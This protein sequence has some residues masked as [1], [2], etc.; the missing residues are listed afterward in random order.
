MLVPR[1]EALPAPLAPRSTK[2]PRTSS[3]AFRASRRGE[4]EA[5]DDPAAFWETYRE[6]AGLV[7]LGAGAAEGKL[8][9][10]AGKG[11][12]AD[13]E[14]D[15]PSDDAWGVERD[16][17]DVGDVRALSWAGLLHPWAL[18]RALETVWASE[19]CVFPSSTPRSPSRAALLP[20][21]T[22]PE[23]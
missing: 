10:A 11:G 6:W 15:K 13:D 19:R 7:A 2:K 23:S 16:K 3:G 22:S 1:P 21:L 9:S 8:R 14:E 20:R 12:E 17:C 4:E 18:R 5:D